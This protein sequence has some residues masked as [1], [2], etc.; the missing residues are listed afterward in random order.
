MCYTQHSHQR[1]VNAPS[2]AWQQQV[3]RKLLL[4]KCI[5]VDATEQGVRN[6]SNGLQYSG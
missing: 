2:Q 4:R 1:S 3:T 5:T 6:H